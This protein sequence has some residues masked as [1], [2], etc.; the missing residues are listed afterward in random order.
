MSK[1]FTSYRELVADALSPK[2]VHSGN[3]EVSIATNLQF[4][5]SL[6]SLQKANEV[7]LR[8]RNAMAESKG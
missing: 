4:K 2:P 3:G 6:K 5:P 1:N 8:L 7:R